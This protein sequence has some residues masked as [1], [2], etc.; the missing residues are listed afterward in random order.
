MRSKRFIGVA[1]VPV[2]LMALALLTRMSMPPN[3]LRRLLRRRVHRGI[4]ADVERNRQCVSARTLDRLGCR[5]YG[6]RKLRMRL[7]CFRGDNDIGAVPRRA[8]RDRQANAA[9][10]TGDE[11]RL[12]LQTHLHPLRLTK[13]R[14]SVSRDL[15]HA[16]WE[17]HTE[18]APTE[19]A[20]PTGSTNCERSIV[21]L[22]Q[23][24]PHYLARRRGG[25]RG[26]NLH[27]ARHFVCR[28]MLATM[29]HQGACRTRPR[30]N[31]PKPT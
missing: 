30:A 10:R 2:R 24:P 18:R 25:Y 6:A 5:M 17:T 23:H 8:Q 28:K 1:S 29:R 4:V 7:G 20:R 19:P 15:T 13:L 3:V 12:V 16:L 26:D 9:G 11:Q 27:C 21:D 22:L 14:E 31:W